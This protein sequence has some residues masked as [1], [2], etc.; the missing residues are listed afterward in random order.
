MLSD[1]S[2]ILI[3]QDQINN[4]DIPPPIEVGNKVRMAIQAWVKGL[5]DNSQFAIPLTMPFTRDGSFPKIGVR[6]TTEPLKTDPPMVTNQVCLWTVIAFGDGDLISEIKGCDLNII[7]LLGSNR[8]PI[9]IEL[10]PKLLP[11]S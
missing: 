4:I 6:F 5:T 1:Q 2:R 3:T 10:V 9:L 8:K 7:R 11:T